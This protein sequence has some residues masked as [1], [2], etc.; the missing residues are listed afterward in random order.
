MYMGNLLSRDNQ[1]SIAV[2]NRR[3][4]ALMSCQLCGSGN[5][6]ELAAEMIIHFSGLKNLDKAGVWV[7]PRLLVCLNCGCSHFTVPESELA[8]IAHTLGISSPTLEYEGGTI[9]EGE[10]SDHLLGFP[11]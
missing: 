10:E 5:E 4:E 7:F 8:T 1:R 2:V 3:M 11:S 9:S 6:A